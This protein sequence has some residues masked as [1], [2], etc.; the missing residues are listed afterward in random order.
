[1]AL[2]LAKFCHCLPI[3]EIPSLIAPTDPL[4]LSAA[5]LKSP[6]KN[7]PIASPPFAI[8]V[9]KALIAITIVEIPVITVLI[10]SI[11]P[12][13]TN[14][15]AD[16]AAIKAPPIITAIPCKT[17][18]RASNTTFKALIIGL[19]VLCILEKL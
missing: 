9:I 1:M 6:L 2:L 19:T 15:T 18:F 3:S 17:G 4:A 14:M 10:V 5:P 12:A 11:A 8:A 13:T 7:F 16:S